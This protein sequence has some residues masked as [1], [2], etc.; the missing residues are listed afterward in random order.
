[1]MMRVRELLKSCGLCGKIRSAE[2]APFWSLDV[3]SVTVLNRPPGSA[4]AISAIRHGRGV[5]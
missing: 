3:A 5:S 1:M 4:G 2:I